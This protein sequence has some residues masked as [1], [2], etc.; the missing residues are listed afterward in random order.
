[1]HSGDKVRANIKSTKSN[2]KIQSSSSDLTVRQKNRELFYV[3]TWT[4]NLGKVLLS[5]LLINSG[6][7]PCPDLDLNLTL[8]P[9]FSL[10]NF[11][12]TG[13]CVFCHSSSYAFLSL[14]RSCLSCF[15]PLISCR[16][17][18]ITICISI[19]PQIWDDG[20]RHN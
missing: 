13:R 8:F 7:H 16:T 6:H 12:L 19:G 4:K 18:S 9:L 17:S 11:Q 5:G 2:E 20:L 15:V 3:V 14:A 1:M 10:W